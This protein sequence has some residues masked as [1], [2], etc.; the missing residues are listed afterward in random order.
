M[1]YLQL[2]YPHSIVDPMVSGVLG[3]M[4]DGRQERR[5]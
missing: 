3:R 1:G 4:V 5:A 2:N